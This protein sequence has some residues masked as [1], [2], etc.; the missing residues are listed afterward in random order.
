PEEGEVCRCRRVNFAGKINSISHSI[1]RPRLPFTMRPFRWKG[2]NQLIS[3]RC[4]VP[5]S[6]ACELPKTYESTQPSRNYLTRKH[7]ALAWNR[8]P[9]NLLKRVPR[10]I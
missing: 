4:V 7:C 10:F 6:A 5:I 3:A 9:A 2:R 8:K 1:P